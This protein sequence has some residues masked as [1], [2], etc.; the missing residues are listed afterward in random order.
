MFASTIVNEMIEL[1][2][3]HLLNLIPDDVQHVDMFRVLLNTVITFEQYLIDIKFFLDNQRSNVLS[4]V[5][6]NIDEAIV[7]SRCRTYLVRSRELLQSNENLA[8]SWTTIEVGDDE[9]SFEKNEQEK[10]QQQQQQQQ[11]VVN[12]L[13][14]TINLD[15]LDANIF[16]FPRTIIV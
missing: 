12:L 5:V 11:S 2:R 7:K 10:A 9:Q 15:E 1:I 16:R 8:T 3:E 13:S 14:S 6:S 4:S